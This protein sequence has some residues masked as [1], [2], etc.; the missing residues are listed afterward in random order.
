MKQLTQYFGSRLRNKILVFSITLVLF[1]LLASSGSM[2]TIARDAAEN[3]IR[4]DLV[5]TVDG[6]ARDIDDLFVHMRETLAITRIAL[7]DK[8]LDADDAVLRLRDMLTVS[9]HSALQLVEKD[10]ASIL[11]LRDEFKSAL[12]E[13][14]LDPNV[15][16]DIA[17]EDLEDERSCR[18]QA[19]LIPIPA[20]D[21]CLLRA[22]MRF[23]A[24]ALYAYVDLRVLHERLRARSLNVKGDIWL[25]DA[26]GHP[27]CGSSSSL[28][29]SQA[30]W[31]LLSTEGLNTGARA[32]GIIPLHGEAGRQLSGGIAI[33]EHVALAAVAAV[34]HGKEHYALDTMLQYLMFWIIA[35]IAVATVASL[36]FARGIS[37]P[38]N[39]IARVATIVKNG[40]LRMRV[41]DLRRRDEIGVLGTRIDE[42]I[43]GLLHKQL[44]LDFL[45]F[46][47]PITGLPNRWLFHDRLEHALAKARRK[48]T[49]LAVLFLDLDQFKNINDT[50]GHS[51]GD[52]LLKSF[53]ERLR[54][55]LREQDTVVRLG[56]DEFLILLDEV[57]S[58]AN[59]EVV[60]EKI[61]DAVRVPFSLDGYE[62]YVSCSIGISLGPRDGSAV[63]ELIKQADRAM[64][65]SKEQG[66]GVYNFFSDALKETM[67]RH[68]DLDHRLR[69]ALEKGQLE[70]Y[71]QPQLDLRTGRVVS[72]EVLLRWPDERNGFVASPREFIP[73]AEESGL[74]LALEE[75]VLW[76]ASAQASRWRSQ[77][78]PHVVVTVNLSARQFR[79]PG[80]TK[81]IADTLAGTGLR[82]KDLQLELTETVLLED[83][84]KVGKLMN[85][86]K[87][88]GLELTIDDF[89]T[90]FSSLNYLRHLP[91]DYLKVPIEFAG[92]V[93]KDQN[94]TAVALAILSLAKG[95]G[96]RVVAE[97][98]ESRD[99]LVFFRRYNCDLVQGYLISRP[100][101]SA[102]FEAYMRQMAAG[103]NETPCPV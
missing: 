2:I 71:Y 5:A 12:T 13:A 62:V 103:Q 100:L 93:E 30:L 59:V 37:A 55:C 40:D 90:G 9:G 36:L 29:E 50:L 39:E 60:A 70:L 96:L 32:G 33:A 20:L 97:G 21:T 91:L 34:P 45:A 24:N 73:L 82:G 74:I 72:A 1:T 18:Q 31:D 3:A 22:C 48:D 46:H 6:L 87:E 52:L 27:V 25:V 15:L 88:I 42:M 65:S 10:S 51:A 66:R 41:G 57:G 17:N 56:G 98:V 77:G 84:S 7:D 54:S 53:G 80:L 11:L 68:L 8:T 85:E 4:E 95:L 79:Y 19:A 38:I 47:D 76:R 26:P 63:T 58:R 23:Q 61:L 81:R 67:H 14:G 78:L 35:G 64:Y 43:N 89:G 16:L 102:H 92:G 28:R 44:R 83:S 75:W 69:T 99:Q 86:L 94:D 101:S 49:T